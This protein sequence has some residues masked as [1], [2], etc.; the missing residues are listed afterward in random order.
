MTKGT[1]AGRE[2]KEGREG[3][4][5]REEK[6]VEWKAWREEKQDGIREE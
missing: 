5:E 1:T 3:D 2:R 6:K 4:R